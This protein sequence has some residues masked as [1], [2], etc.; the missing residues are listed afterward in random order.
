MDGAS[1]AKPNKRV[2]ITHVA[3]HAGVSTAAVSKV[4]RNAYDVSEAMRE[5]VRAA[6]DALGCRA[7]AAA[8]GMRGRTYTIGVVLD[9]VRNAFFA[10]ILDGIRDELR[11]TDST[12]L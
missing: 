9:N 1:A 5:K 3:R 4:M 10:A 7:R 6:T 12:V 8:R 2:T 11:H